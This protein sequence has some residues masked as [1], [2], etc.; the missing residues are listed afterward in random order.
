MDRREWVAGYG[1]YV[2]GT[3]SLSAFLPVMLKQMNNVAELQ[4][5]VCAMQICHSPKIRLCTDFESVYP[6][7]TS[8]A[9]R[10]RVS[11]WY[12]SSGPVPTTFIWEQLLHEL[13]RLER[14][15]EWVETLPL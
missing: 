15:V 3:T 14:M 5:T 9:C 4:A 12:G 13:D 11:G 7:A 10:W 8:A 2:D 6:G 1:I